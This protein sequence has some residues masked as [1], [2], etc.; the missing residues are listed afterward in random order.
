MKNTVERVNTGEKQ[1]RI[2]A[3]RAATAVAV[4]KGEIARR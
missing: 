1:E 4:T 2:T 3:T